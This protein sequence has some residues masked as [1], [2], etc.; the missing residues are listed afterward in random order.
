MQRLSLKTV[1]MLSA[2]VHVVSIIGAGFGLVATTVS[3]DAQYYNR[4]IYIP[5]PVYRPGPSRFSAV[6]TYYGAANGIYRRYRPYDIGSPNFFRNNF[7]RPNWNDY[8]RRTG[9][10]F[11]RPRNCFGPYC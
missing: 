7:P 4:R 8:S 11:V 5:A 3:A 6:G 2:T 10:V 9:G 1:G